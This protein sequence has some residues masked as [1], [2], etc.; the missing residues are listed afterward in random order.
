MDE[1]RFRV[2]G[3]LFDVPDEFLLGF[4]ASNIPSLGSSTQYSTHGPASCQC[5]PQQAAG[6]DPST[7]DTDNYIQ[8]LYWIPDSWFCHGPSFA[9]VNLWTLCPL[10]LS[11]S[12]SPILPPPPFFYANIMNNKNFTSQA[13]LVQFILGS[14]DILRLAFRVLGRY[15]LCY[16]IIWVWHIA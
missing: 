4:P 16:I 11:V 14:S 1:L 3:Y 5:K 10:S 15:L 6:H 12:L 2:S 13:Q 7:W 9:F 8:D